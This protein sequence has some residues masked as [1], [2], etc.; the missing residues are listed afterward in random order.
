ME[1]MVICA[2]GIVTYCF[3]LALKDMVA[4]L[5]QEGMLANPLSE[6][7]ACW[8]GEMLRCFDRKLLAPRRTH[9]RKVILL[10]C[11]AELP[12]FRQPHPVRVRVR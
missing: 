11:R 3:Y 1:P 5:R 8:K 4:D 7:I 9:A 6:K 2:L 10:P 12:S